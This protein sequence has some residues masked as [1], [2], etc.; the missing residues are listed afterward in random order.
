MRGEHGEP[1]VVV[2][3][4]D[5]GAWRPEQVFTRRWI[6]FADDSEGWSYTLFDGDWCRRDQTLH[7]YNAGGGPP[8]VG[9]GAEPGIH[10]RIWLAPGES[11][12]DSGVTIERPSGAPLAWDPP[13]LSVETLREF[14][15]EITAEH[16]G[17]IFADASDE[18]TYYCET[19]DDHLPADEQTTAYLAQP[20]PEPL[21]LSL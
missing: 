3:A 11:V 14:G 21:P 5:D 10:W 15:Y 1:A 17:D 9:R 6:R 18:R 2:Y 8:Y 13:G 7:L 16:P 20:V 12:R 4:M 19:C